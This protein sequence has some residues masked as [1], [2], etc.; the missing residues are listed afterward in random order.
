MLNW[1]P[2]SYIR[3]VNG[4]IRKS[5]TTAPPVFCIGKVEFSATVIAN[6]ISGSAETGQRQKKK[7]NSVHRYLAKLRL[8]KPLRCNASA[9]ETKPGCYT[10]WMDD[11]DFEG[12]LVLEKMMEIGLLD[13]FWE[14][15]DADDLRKV[16][17]LLRHAGI[18]SE[19]ITTVLKKMAEADTQH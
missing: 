10:G 2:T 3:A 15:I 11:T 12:T 8:P 14:A 4:V 19:T 6:P 7:S 18:D 1:I 13:V 9:R 17:S 5:L 16:A